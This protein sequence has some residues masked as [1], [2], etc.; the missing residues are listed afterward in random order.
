MDFEQNWLICKGIQSWSIRCHFGEFSNSCSAAPCLEDQNTGTQHSLLEHYLSL[1]TIDTPCQSSLVPFL[2]PCSQ[3]HTSAKR[4][5]HRCVWSSICP[6][7][8]PLLTGQLEVLP[9]GPHW[10]HHHLQVWN[11][12]GTPQHKGTPSNPWV[13]VIESWP[14]RRG[15]VKLAPMS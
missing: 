10:R 5:I 9:T 15:H 11:I 7:G 1:Q 6:W 3:H 8:S 13:R 2:G 12:I 4:N 14:P